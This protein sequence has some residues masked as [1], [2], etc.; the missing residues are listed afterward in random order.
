M[1]EVARNRRQR[2]DNDVV[3]P[4]DEGDLGLFQF[5]LRKHF[6]EMDCDVECMKS[7]AS[8]TGVIGTARSHGRSRPQNRQSF[9]GYL[10]P[11]YESPRLAEGDED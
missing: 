4:I 5:A 1:S 7:A 10:Q 9:Y 6:S 11:A 8:D 2:L 3:L